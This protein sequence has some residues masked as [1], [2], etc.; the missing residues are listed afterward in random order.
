MPFLL[1]SVDGVLVTK[2]APD[3]RNEHIDLFLSRKRINSR[4]KTATGASFLVTTG[5]NLL[6]Q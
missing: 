4:L 6:N 2:L 5:N 1:L 3:N